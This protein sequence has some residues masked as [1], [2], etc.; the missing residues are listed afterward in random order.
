MKFVL[1][2]FF[3]FLV[4]YLPLEEISCTGLLCKFFDLLK[5][6][7]I[8]DKRRKKLKALHES[9]L[10]CKLQNLFIALIFDSGSGRVLGTQNE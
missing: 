2:L 5:S 7:P 10:N 1:S 4:F 3:T 8:T 6:I 9:R